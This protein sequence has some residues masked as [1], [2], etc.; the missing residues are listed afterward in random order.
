MP[1]ISLRVAKEELQILKAYAKIHNSS[2]SEVIRDTMLEKIEENYDLK[3]FAEYEKEKSL[4]RV[5]TKP[6]HELWKELD[7]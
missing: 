6:V 1:T 4:G 7:L 2:L 5:K 3:V